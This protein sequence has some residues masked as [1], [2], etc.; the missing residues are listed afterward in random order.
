MTKAEALSKHIEDS[1]D[2][3]IWNYSDEEKLDFILDLADRGY[4]QI[5]DIF[6]LEFM[7]NILN[8][9]FSEQFSGLE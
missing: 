2:D 6:Y 1:W 3:L 4:L 7:E 5:N 9:Y 8:R